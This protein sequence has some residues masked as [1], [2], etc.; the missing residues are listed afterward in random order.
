ME[1]GHLLTRFGLTI[2]EVPLMVSPG[3][4]CLWARGVLFS[5]LIYNE[6]FSLHVATIFFCIPVFYP[7]LGL[8]L[9]LL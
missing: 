6:A 8:Y 4:Y 2:L 3:F 1:S 7:K 9:I 5:L